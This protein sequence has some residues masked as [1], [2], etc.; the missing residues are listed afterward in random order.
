MG[1][2]GSGQGTSQVSLA[3]LEGPWVGPRCAGIEAEQ[4][5]LRSPKPRS[6]GKML[7][8]YLEKPTSKVNSF[9]GPA[10]AAA[11]RELRPAR[12]R[13]R[14]W[15]RCPT[16]NSRSPQISA[17]TRVPTPICSARKPTPAASPG[18][19]LGTIGIWQI[20]VLARIRRSATS[21]TTAIPKVCSLRATDPVRQDRAGWPIHGCE[22]RECERRSLRN[23]VSDPP[24][25]CAPAA[26]FTSLITSSQVEDPSSI[27]GFRKK[28]QQPDHSCCS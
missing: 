26:F 27:T 28:S 8:I 2:L 25:D 10:A 21:A 16:I 18:L 1:P 19:R 12:W 6:L 23:A 17:R 3:H 5:R 14:R 7:P 13:R 22:L 20:S 11:N 15:W 9:A 4:C 24:F